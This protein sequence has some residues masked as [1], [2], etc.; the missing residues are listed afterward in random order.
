MKKPCVFY[1]FSYSPIGSAIDLKQIETF[2]IYFQINR[3]TIT[4]TIYPSL[5]IHLPNIDQ[6]R[7]L[8]ML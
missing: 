4:D 2:I 1:V 3:F 6:I 5:K 7:N 8:T